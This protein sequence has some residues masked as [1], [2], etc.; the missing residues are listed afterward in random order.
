M[1]KVWFLIVV[2]LI[3]LCVHIWKQWPDQYVHLV[4]C[5]VGQGDAILMWQ[6][7]AQIL[8]DAGRA[9]N[10][11]LECL[12][13]HL[14]FWD[15]Q[16]ELAVATHADGDHIGG[17]P[18][19][20]DNYGVRHILVEPIGKE[21]GDFL[22]FYEAVL[23]KLEHESGLHIPLIG[24]HLT[25]GSRL[26][27]VTIS[28]RVDSLQFVNSE[29][30]LAETQLWA[31]ALESSE[32]VESYNDRSIVL[33]ANIGE[34][35]I[36]LTGDLEYEGEQA[37]LNQGL[38]SKI[39]VL[40][41]GHHGSKTSTSDRLLTTIQ[42]EIAVISSG[43]NNNYGHPAPEV[44]KKLKEKGVKIMRTDEEGSVHFIT[45]GKTLWRK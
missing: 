43:Q 11:V 21:T 19:V 42:P 17:F 20:F 38:L 33:L 30:S 13:E 23:R 28:P 37:L 7:H 10:Q 18:A 8:I 39:E 4:F 3:F 14:P 9:D 34:I 29:R 35:D 44:I 6:G 24:Q 15:R 41:V 5:D 2:A 1:K 26:T 22:E 25:I 40:K 45:D 32:H 12:T 16:L 36:L 27:L 31:S